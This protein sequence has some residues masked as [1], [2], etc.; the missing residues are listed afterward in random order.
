VVEHDE[1]TIRSADHIIDLGPGA[2]VQGGQL[3]GV[4]TPIEIR[5]NKNSLTGDYLSG[6]K[7]VSKPRPRRSGSGG[8]IQLRGATG[9]NLQKV[10]IDLPLGTM[11]SVTGVSGSGKSTLVID[12]LYRALAQHFHGSRIEPAPHQKILGLEHIDRVIQINQKPIGRTPRSTPST[13]VGLMSAIRDL[14]ALLPESKVRGYRPGQFSYNVKAGRCSVCEGAGVVRVEMHFLSDVYVK[15]ET[16]GG[17]RYSPETRSVRFKGKSIADVLD[18]SIGEALPHFE[19]HPTIHRRLETLV[20][21]GLDY[22]KLG[23]SSTT[24]SGGEAQR[25]KLSRELSKRG[26]GKTLYILDEPTTGLHF[27]DISKLITLLQDLVDQGN[28]VLV[29]EHNLDVIVSS[30]HVID[31]GP[32]GGKAGGKVLAAGTPEDIAKSSHSETGRYLRQALDRWRSLNLD[33]QV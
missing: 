9:N 21:V 12:T 32:E 6:R 8:K 13:Y 7:V 29:I 20:R 1:D 10:S 23:Q 19:N 11:I 18:M 30:D 4:G 22:L 26:T 16:C 3:M 28:T 2:G 24:L 31:M 5:D 14:Y 33:Y 17:S 27:E 25:V 15:C